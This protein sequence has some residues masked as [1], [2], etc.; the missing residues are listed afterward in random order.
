MR[1][2]CIVWL[3]GLVLFFFISGMYIYNSYNNLFE[4]RTSYLYDPGSDNVYLVELIPYL[5]EYDK[6]TFLNPF[7]S[8]DHTLPI[9]AEYLGKLNSILSEHQRDTEL[10]G[11]DIDAWREKTSQFIDSIKSD[12]LNDKRLY[13]YWYIEYYILPEADYSDYMSIT[14][15][16]IFSNYAIVQNE[17]IIVDAVV[18][19]T[20]VK[21][22]GKYDRSRSIEI[23][24]GAILFKEKA[25]NILYMSGLYYSD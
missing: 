5:N 18:T 22:N 24:R 8:L 1:N 21:K 6:W 7:Q 11:N 19:N 10:L 13:E 25:A 17:I 2:K 20:V 16:N 4:S 15:D 9:Y 3:L 14:L 23:I 12:L